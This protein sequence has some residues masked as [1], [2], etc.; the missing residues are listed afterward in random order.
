MSFKLASLILLV[1]TGNLVAAI[2]SFTPD[3]LSDFQT[4]GSKVHQ[5]RDSTF[6]SSLTDP[7]AETLNE[8]RF[9]TLISVPDQVVYTHEWIGATFTPSFQSTI[10]T[11][12]FS[13]ELSHPNL[14]NLPTPLYLGLIQAGVLYFYTEDNIIVKSFEPIEDDP[15]FI[16]R[17]VSNLTESDF[18][19]FAPADV[20]GGFQ[21]V[22][23]SDH[24]DF[25]GS[26]SEIQFLYGTA[27]ATGN[28][29]P[30]RFTDF[31]NSSLNITTIPEPSS[32]V[33][34]FVALTAILSRR[35]K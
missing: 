23:A 14:S 4:S 13:I 21:N 25:S 22:D 7:T 1:F 26:G 5:L 24:P 8:L 32:S 9:E 18:A 12:N 27:S 20:E 31:R 28:N 17:S 35:K 10:A 15:N 16:Q 33:L 29:N 30:Q 19:R 2:I 11:I 34:F 6:S 3:S